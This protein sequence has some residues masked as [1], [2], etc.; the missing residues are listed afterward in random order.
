M[1]FLIVKVK[2]LRLN[3][4]QH[5]QV[6]FSL[7]INLTLWS[8]LVVVL[9]RQNF[10]RYFYTLFVVVIAHYFKILLK[11]INSRWSADLHSRPTSTSNQAK[12]HRL[13]KHQRVTKDWTLINCSLLCPCLRG[14]R[15]QLPRVLI[16]CQARWPPR[17]LKCRQVSARPFLGSIKTSWCSSRTSW[18]I[19]IRSTGGCSRSITK[20]W[21]PL[22]NNIASR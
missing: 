1:S 6:T 5:L 7:L 21:G 20:Y 22:K 10:K 12:L 8:Q 11:W 19:C 4:E 3:S 16:S 9:F 2:E 18:V 14:L 17:L 15:D 13:W